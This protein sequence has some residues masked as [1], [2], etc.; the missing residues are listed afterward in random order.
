MKVTL[1]TTKDFEI[2]RFSKF[3]QLI[4]ITFRFVFET[5]GKIVIFFWKTFSYKKIPR[6]QFFYVNKFLISHILVKILSTIEIEKS[7]DS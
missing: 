5:F 3:S 4:S 2:R 1:N 7:V 6:E